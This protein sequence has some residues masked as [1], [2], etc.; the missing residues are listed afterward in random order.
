MVLKTYMVKY[1]SIIILE[2]STDVLPLTCVTAS[3]KCLPVLNVM[4]K[5]RLQ[6]QGITDNVS[7]TLCDS[8]AADVVTSYK[9]LG[10]CL[11]NIRCVVIKKKGILREGP[12]ELVSV[13]ALEV[14][15]C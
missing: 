8:V 11:Q 3:M 9:P 2:Q 12:L 7:V 5:V 10:W 1:F 15:P 13:S 4:V 14:S 6:S